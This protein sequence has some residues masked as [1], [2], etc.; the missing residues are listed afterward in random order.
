MVAADMSP[1]AHACRLKIAL[2]TSSSDITC[3][4]NL[5]HEALQY[6]SKLHCVSASCRLSVEEELALLQVFSSS[7]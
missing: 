7:L 3:P 5:E 4:W 6:I 1:D 2:V